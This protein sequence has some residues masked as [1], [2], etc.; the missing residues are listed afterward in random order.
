MAQAKVM[1]K[2]MRLQAAVDFMVSYG[3]AILIVAISIYVIARLGIFSNQLTQP[4][5]TTAPSFS[6]GD[7]SLARNGLLTFVI[8][9]AVG[10]TINVTGVSC[11]SGVNVTG[12]QPQNGNIKMQSNS[13]APQYY[14]G[15][16]FSH[17]L[18]IYS[19]G[20]ATININCY[21]GSGISSQNLGT[22]YS[23]YVWFNYTYTGLPSTYHTTERVLQFTTR[24]S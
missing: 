2:K 21:G 10:G 3:I 9:Q 1:N 24:S 18:L 23:G 8:A 16:Q 4:T 5:C 22:P 7:F 6:C 12:N 15:T 11:S 17:G 20:S 19:D 13:V 14:V